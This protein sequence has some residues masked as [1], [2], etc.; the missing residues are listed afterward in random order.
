[1]D[2]IPSMV[3]THPGGGRSLLILRALTKS[4]V[5]SSTCYTCADACL[6]QDDPK[7]LEDCIRTCLDCAGVMRVRDPLTSETK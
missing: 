1:M 6:A 3:K 7:E 2:R 4:I 5:C